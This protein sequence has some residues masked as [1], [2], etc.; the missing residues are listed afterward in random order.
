M[1]LTLRSS[2]CAKKVVALNLTSL[3]FDMLVKCTNHVL[4]F[5]LK[6]ISVH[7]IQNHLFLFVTPFLK[8][9]RSLRDSNLEHGGDI[10]HFLWEF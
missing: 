4:I 8:L 10:M 3:V 2:F 5:Q 6:L 7:Y 1:L 9:M